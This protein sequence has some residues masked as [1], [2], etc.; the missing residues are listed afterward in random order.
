M[1]GSVTDKV[2][3]IKDCFRK[4]ILDILDNK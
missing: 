2:I 4:Q 3:K 1:E